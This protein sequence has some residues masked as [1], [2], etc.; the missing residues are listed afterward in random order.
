MITACEYG[1]S[2]G[3]ELPPVD[4]IGEDIAFQEIPEAPSALEPEAVETS[5]ELTE[6]PA[7]TFTPESAPNM[8]ETTT[9]EGESHEA[10]EVGPGEELLPMADYGDE[11]TADVPDVPIEIPED[12]ATIDVADS[13]DQAADADGDGV[14]EEQGEQATGADG[15]AVVETSE[16][17][18]EAEV[19]DADSGHIEVG[20]EAVE[21]PENVDRGQATWSGVERE[22]PIERGTV[23][24]P[25]ITDSPESLPEKGLG[26]DQPPGHGI[27]PSDAQ[28][29]I[30]DD[31][32]AT[33]DTSS[34]SEDQTDKAINLDAD[35]EDLSDPRHQ[36]GLNW[37]RPMRKRFRKMKRTF[38][39]PAMR[40]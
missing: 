34:S 15:A 5:S 14:A 29:D 20:D 8:E 26:R 1:E 35:D 23:E 19:G 21:I 37:R 38:F 33:S 7:E 32:S 22:S 30:S 27:Q 11:L 18:D 4:D 10:A 12:K 17:S 28:D 3:G 24:R 16:Q 25:E 13:S 6:V 40:R 39:C 2:G 31:D 9:G 36:K